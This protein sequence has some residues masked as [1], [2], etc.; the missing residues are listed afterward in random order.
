MDLTS[1]SNSKWATGLVLGVGKLVPPSVG[2]RLARRTASRIAANRDDPM[3]QAVRANQWMVS[4]G[5]LTGDAL[6][7]V[8]R[9]TFEYSGRF[10]YDLYHVMENPDALMGMVAV[11]ETFERVLADDKKRPHVYAGIHLGNFDLMGRALGHHG[12]SQQLLSVADPNEG[13]QW[14]NEMRARYGF[15]VTPVSI[16]A[17][18]RAAR[19]LAEGGS[20]T[21]G[22][23]RP[24]LD[25]RQFPHFFGRPAPLPL[26]HIRLAMRA[27]APVVVISAILGDDGKYR[28]QASEPLEME[29][30]GDTTSDMIANGERALRVAEKL[31]ERAPH[32]WAMTH[33]V[34][35]D[36][37]GTV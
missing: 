30:G 21:T 18:K 27:K 35:P 34:W 8:V 13:Y 24:L 7:E 17:L 26:L 37:V 11:D 6:D 15:E 25:A 23:D 3:V 12:W 36:V 29:T 32:Q 10:L 2:H 33:P 9:E 5:T 28:V 19:R 1:I 14:Q 20:V 16:E 4:R 31:I 22:L